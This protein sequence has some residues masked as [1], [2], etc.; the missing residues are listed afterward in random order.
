MIRDERERTALEVEAVATVVPGCETGSASTR[1]PSIS[2][3]PTG[4]SWK[5]TVAGML[6]EVDGKERRRE[7]PRD[8]V[9]ERVDRRRRAPDVKLGVLPPE[10][11]EEAQPL[12][13][14]EVEMR[15]QEMDPPSRAEAS[16]RAA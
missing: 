13:V 8:A 10:R 2:Q 15:Q 11:L 3:A 6:R 12:D 14:V 4:T 9:P 1:M 16:R 5:L 7:R